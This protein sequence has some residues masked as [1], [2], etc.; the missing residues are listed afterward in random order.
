MEGYSLQRNSSSMNSII[1]P[2]RMCAQLDEVNLAQFI[3]WWINYGKPCI[4][5]IHPSK[6]SPELV[7]IC[8]TVDPKDVEV[9]SFMEKAV[10]NTGAKLW[11]ITNEKK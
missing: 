9:M 4:L 3:G 6:K 2:Q 1:S 10:S 8:F 11:N 5:T 7:G